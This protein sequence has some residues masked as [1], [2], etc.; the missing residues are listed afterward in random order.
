M[1]SRGGTVTIVYNH[2]PRITAAIRPAV[3]VIVQET[4]ADIEIGAKMRV[5]V[6]TGALMGS[7]QPEMTGETSGAVYTEIEYSVYQE[8]GTSR[9]AATPYM[10]PAAENERRHFMRKLGDLEASLE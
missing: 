7:I 4:L 8:Y 3:R 9:M 10:T 6:D 5:P 2:F 1:A